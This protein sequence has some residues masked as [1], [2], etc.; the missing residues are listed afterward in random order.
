MKRYN[1]AAYI[2]AYEDEEALSQCVSSLLKQTY[3]IEKI[4]IVDNSKIA[5]KIAKNNDK[6]LIYHCPENIGISGGIE[7]A[8]DW[9]I[10]EN[11]DF[12]WT[13]D[14]DS[15]PE[16]NCL[17]LLIAEYTDLTKKGEPVGIIA[18]LSLDSNTNVELP[19]SVFDTYKFKP[20]PLHDKETYKCDVAITSGSLVSMCAAK[21]TPLPEK[22][23]FI[24][25]VDWD[26]CMKIRES[27]YGIFMTRKT[28]MSHRF[29]EMKRVSLPF[30]SKPL[31]TNNYSPLR[32]YYICRNHT[33]I[34]TK[35]A[36]FSVILLVILSRLKYLIKS[37]LK[38]L[39]FEDNKIN[40][41]MSGVEGTID[42]F[43]QRLGKKTLR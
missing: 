20:S 40:K 8:I 22:D 11:Y 3:S 1:I 2:T 31:F 18:P 26:Y 28:V 34:L 42:G 24:D 25:A 17:D 21:E 29:S 36:D 6:I 19:G 23:L 16:P 43:T 39:V 5:S 4:L 14:Q 38:I 37:S 15:K 33:Y 32:R 30:F 27:G 10:A 7:L 12:L 35:Y 41:I 13:F 9:A